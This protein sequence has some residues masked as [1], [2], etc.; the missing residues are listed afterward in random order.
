MSLRAYNDTKPNL[1]RRPACNKLEPEI[2][3]RD[4]Q[5][6]FH[7]RSCEDS[8]LSLFLGTRCTYVK[9]MSGQR[10]VKQV[11]VI[12]VSG[13]EPESPPPPPSRDGTPFPAIYLALLNHNVRNTLHGTF[14]EK[15]GSGEAA[16]I[17]LI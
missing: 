3:S 14:K 10:R 5:K 11:A 7:D 16:R 6:L 4:P 15:W 1:A 12:G 17:V 9:G 8:L 13:S 2:P